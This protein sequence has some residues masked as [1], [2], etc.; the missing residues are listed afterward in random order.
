MKKLL[1]FSVALIISALASF[2]Q[3]S[4]QLPQAS[5]IFGTTPAFLDISEFDLKKDTF[6]GKSESAVVEGYR[7]IKS[8]KSGLSHITGV[9][10]INFSEGSNMPIIDLS[11]GYSSNFIIK[12]FPKNFLSLMPITELKSPNLIFL[13]KK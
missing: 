11:K 7:Q 4:F 2:G 10:E 6:D 1:L 5:I 3:N 12:E 13:Q 8:T 9:P